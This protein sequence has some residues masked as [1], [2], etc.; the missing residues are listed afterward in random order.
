MYHGRAHPL[1]L[2]G[3]RVANSGTWP[4]AIYCRRGGVKGERG[5]G[6]GGGSKGGGGGKMSGGGPRSVRGNPPTAI[7]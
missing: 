5:G 7:W 1:R 2:A 4:N 6:G 3:G